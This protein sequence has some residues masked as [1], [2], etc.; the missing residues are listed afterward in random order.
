MCEIQPADLL[1]KFSVNSQLR[2]DLTDALSF[3]DQLDEM[4]KGLK[5]FWPRLLILVLLCTIAFYAYNRI[6]YAP[7]YTASSTFTVSSSN[8]SRTN[9][10]YNE[11]VAKQ[12]GKVFP[13]LLSS[14][15]MTKLVAEDLGMDSV[16][17]TITTENLFNTNMITL[18]V[19][20]DNPKLAYD[21]L[22][23]IIK[24]YPTVT[25][26]I[27]GDVTMNLV[28]GTG[29]PTAP[30]NGV[31]YKQQLLR[32]FIIGLVLAALFLYLYAITRKTIKKEKD[33][34]K[35]L[36]VPCLATLPRVKMKKRSNTSR[37]RILIDYEHIPR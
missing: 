2:G 23:S 36:N 25:E 10:N 5:K 17:G 6:N 18:N 26:Y 7:E 35:V 34:K 9:G 24:N 32:G 37:Q 30:S 20:A 14:D 27:L 3:S 11:T 29:K 13:Y 15:A 21:I 22:Q 8:T 4:W 28:D 33:L 12:L 16:P 1:R 31:S 19:T